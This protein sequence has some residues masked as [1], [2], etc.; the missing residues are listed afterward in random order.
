MKTIVS[1]NCGVTLFVSEERRPNCGQCGMQVAEVRSEITK[2]KRL[3]HRTK[4]K[5]I[6]AVI[7]VSSLAA[8]TFA[9]RDQLNLSALTKQAQLTSKTNETLVW[10]S[11]P[12]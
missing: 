8:V 2:L 10:V 4:L 12:I 7:V 11:A 1:G 6:S 9:A 5:W 3:R